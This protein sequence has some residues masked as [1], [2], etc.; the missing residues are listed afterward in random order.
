VQS[1]CLFIRLLVS[2]P[3]LICVSA[4]ALQPAGNSDQQARKLGFERIVV[5]G[6]DF[7]HV[8]YLHSTAAGNGMLHVYLEGDGS[9]WI[10]ER[11]V[12]TDPGPRNPLMLKLMALDPAPGMYLGRP[13]YHGLS[14]E[15]AC[16]PAFWTNA[17]YSAPVIASMAR[18]LEL[19]ARDT[20]HNGIVL[21]GYSG[22]GTIAML[23][24]ERV[25]DVRAVI[26]LAGNLD[27]DA[28]TELH[29][30]SR[31]SASLNPSL[32]EPLPDGIY[33]LHMVGDRDRVVPRTLIVPAAAR[34]QHADVVIV[35]GADH[36]CCW[37]SL[38][39]E[40]LETLPE[41]IAQAAGRG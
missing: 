16:N 41:R 35:P 34:Q 8:V 15:P 39:P 2:L 20:N 40:L 14:G 9:P 21:I 30:Y 7:R 6:T 5:K 31:L 1:G 23:L 22:G 3:L 18:A 10:D 27:P 29:D 17:R 13:C 36:T 11:W 24:A 19:V 33:Q 4:C 25:A 12:T 26:T 37:E 38:W 32:Q 28:W